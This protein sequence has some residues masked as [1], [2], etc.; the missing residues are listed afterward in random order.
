MAVLTQVTLPILFVVFLGY[1]LRKIGRV[2]ESVLS[3]I[4]LYVLSPALIFMTMAG[5]NAMMSLLGKI[6]LHVLILSVLLYLSAQLLGR[7]MRGDALERN[8]MSLAAVFTNS[9]FYG[10]PVCMLAFGEEGLGYAAMYVICSSMIQSTAG[11]YIA[12]E[13]S[14]KPL[15]ALAMIFKVPLIYAIVLGKLLSQFD[16]LPPAP[17]MEM[18][19]MLGRS[20]V[21]LG[22]LLLGMQLERIISDWRL[23][24]MANGA[25]RGRVPANEDGAGHGRDS[26]GAPDGAAA[27]SSCGTAFERPCK[28]YILEGTTAGMLKIVGGFVFAMIIL[29]FIEFEPVLRK[30]IILESSMPTA[31]N[32]VVYATEFEC[33]PKL[34]T[35]A[36][37]TATLA[38]VASVA[39][40]LAW[41]GR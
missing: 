21:P 3:R 38:S 25:G 37:M 35:I 34:V 31:V 39:L 19:N 20:A 23:K 7:M 41:L 26:N 10:I 27:S 32:A 17:F 18:I 13:G 15:E 11:I 12:S 14:R 30:V 33:R 4:Q 16:M 2:E 24:G 5:S 29:R 9:G 22:L 28:S 8:A 40:L 1:L 36:I 6:F